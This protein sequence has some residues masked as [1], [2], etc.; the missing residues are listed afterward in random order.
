MNYPVTPEERR[1]LLDAFHAAEHEAYH[2]DLAERV[3]AE[4]ENATAL[5]WWW[6]AA[7]ALVIVVTAALSATFPMGWAS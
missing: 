6:P 7:A 3:N 2:A 4:A 1:A 5:P